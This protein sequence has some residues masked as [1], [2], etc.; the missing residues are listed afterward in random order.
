MGMGANVVRD[1]SYAQTENQSQSLNRMPSLTLGK[2]ILPP[3]L[4]GM[5]LANL[6]SRVRRFTIELYPR[7]MLAI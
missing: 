4:P 6:L 2:N 5:E 7:P 1:I 3:F